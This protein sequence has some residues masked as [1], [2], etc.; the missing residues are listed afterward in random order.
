[1]Y[2][3]SI[4]IEQKNVLQQYKSP[5]NPRKKNSEKKIQLMLIYFSFI[6]Y[7]NN[8]LGGNIIP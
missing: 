8:S 5:H 2:Y 6:P 3:D 7:F 1:M 4:F